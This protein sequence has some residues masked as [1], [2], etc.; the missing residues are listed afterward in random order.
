MPRAAQHTRGSGL[1]RQQP[2]LV[3]S[4]QGHHMVGPRTYH[5]LPAIRSIRSARHVPPMAVFCPPP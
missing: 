1:T 5:D 2:K 3:V 4:R